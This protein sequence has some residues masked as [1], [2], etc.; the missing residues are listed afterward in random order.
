MKPYQSPTSY[1]RIDTRMSH[2]HRTIHTSVYT[3]LYDRHTVYAVSYDRHTTDTV[4]ARITRG[5]VRPDTVS[6]SVQS[7][8]VYIQHSNTAQHN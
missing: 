1:T 7:S 4:Q 8:S 6:T 3:V 5:Q 2:E